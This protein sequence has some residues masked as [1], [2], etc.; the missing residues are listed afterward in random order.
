MRAKDFIVEAAVT[1]K[2]LYGN[3]LPDRD[4]SFWDHVRPRELE[5]PLAVQTMPAYKLKF[6]LLGQYRAEHLDEIVDLIDPDRLELID[7]YRNDK[8]L[9]DK[10]IVIMNDSII[11]GNH[12]ALAAALENKPINYVDLADLDA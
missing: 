1:L 4:E 5:K 12:R 8:R 3:S 11:D 9:S 2:N 6:M 10:I 7:K